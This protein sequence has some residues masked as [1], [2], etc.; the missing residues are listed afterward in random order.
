MWS[1]GPESQ[2]TFLLTSKYKLRVS[3]LV[4]SKRVNGIHLAA[5]WKNMHLDWCQ[6]EIWKVQHHTQRYNRFGSLP[7]QQDRPSPD[8]P[9]KLQRMREEMWEDDWE[10][11]VVNTNSEAQQLCLLHCN[12]KDLYFAAQYD[13]C[14]LLFWGQFWKYG[15]SK[16]AQSAKAD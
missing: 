7:C 9:Q 16:R 2:Q 3:H 12:L 6:N 4:Q 14:L 13:S 10:T 15:D 5:V 8:F 1:T 11:A